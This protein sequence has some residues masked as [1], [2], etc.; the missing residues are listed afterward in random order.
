MK[1]LK[2]LIGG[3]AMIAAPFIAAPIAGALGVS[4]A[5]GTSLIGA[6]IGAL[7]AKAAGVNPLVG[8]GIGGLGAFGM[9][10]G[11]QGTAAGG[12]FGGAAPSAVTAGM[13]PAA[14]GVAPAVAGVTPAVAGAGAGGI[15]GGMGGNLGQAL[16]M[17]ALSSFGKAPQDLTEQERQA[18]AEQ[19]RRQGIQE[20]VFNQAFEQAR[21]VAQR[22]TPDVEGAFARTQIAA[23][24]QL[25]EGVRGATSGQ[26][27]AARRRAALGSTLAGA[28]GTA[29]EQQRADTA[30][31]QAAS[32]FAGLRPPSQSAAEQS[33]AIYGDLYKRRQDYAADLARG[34]GALFGGM[35]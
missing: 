18:L 20:N 24:R 4:S 30:A 7:G 32:A 34:A 1:F 26:R 31:G 9:A 12:L 6:G 17:M 2:K 33:L 23:Q 13:A 35:G 15:L 14:M 28:A 27:D 16:T 11:F 5:V 25:D 19:A 3:I 21:M 29:T 10:G 8:A 22:A